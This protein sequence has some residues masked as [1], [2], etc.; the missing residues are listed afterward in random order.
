MTGIADNWHVVSGLGGGIFFVALV[1]Y[2]HRKPESAITS[3]LARVE[4][5][6]ALTV[7]VAMMLGAMA[8]VLSL[9]VPGRYFTFLFAPYVFPSILAVV[10]LVAWWAAPH[11]RARFPLPRGFFIRRAPSNNTP[12]PDARASA[13]LNQPPSARAGER[14]R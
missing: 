12:H 1:I 3:T 11:V 6:F 14:G 5:A 2:T 10:Y 9:V 7:L 8:M 13:S 4:Y